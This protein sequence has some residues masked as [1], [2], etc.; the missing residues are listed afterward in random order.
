[1]SYSLRGAL[2]GALDLDLTS[3]GARDRDAECLEGACECRDLAVFDFVPEVDEPLSLPELSSS[4]SIV[5]ECVGCLTI[6]AVPP[7][8][9]C[10]ATLGGWL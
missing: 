6:L 3:E 1:M 4:T 8:T 9:L 5:C 10:A 7:C 2:L